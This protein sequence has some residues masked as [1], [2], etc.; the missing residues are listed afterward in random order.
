MKRLGLALA[1]CLSLIGGA[2]AQGGM[3]PGPGM[4][5]STGG[6]TCSSS[7]GNAFLARLTGSPNSTHQTAYCTLIDGLV[8]DSVFTKLDALYMFAADT[9]ANALLNL[10]SSSNN[11]TN[12]SATFAAD[13]GFTGNG[14]NQY[15]NTTVDPTATTQFTQN[16]AHISLWFNTTT[17]NNAGGRHGYIDGGATKGTYGSPGSGANPPAVNVNSNFDLVVTAATNN[18]EKKHIIG[19]RSTSAA[20]QIYLNGVND[21][22]DT[23]ASQTIPSGA[24]FWIGCRNLGG[25]P[26]QCTNGQFMMY[27]IGA[28]LSSTDAGNL[29]ARVHTY[30][31]T[32]AGIP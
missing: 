7:Q 15:V 30:L 18:S 16:S 10:I 28:S 8:T 24:T 17:P 27:S 19:N 2:L 31:Q 21:G 23:V 29:Y 6:V 4:V 3:G 26:N 9:S 5:H 32:I 25:S 13:A 14:T 20:R 12:V 1:L 11:A 22:S